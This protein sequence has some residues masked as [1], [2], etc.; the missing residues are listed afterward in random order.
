MKKLLE[1]YGFLASIGLIIIQA[2][3]SYFIVI[4][5]QETF[6]N[7]ENYPVYYGVILF[8]LNLLFIF[9]PFN[10]FGKNG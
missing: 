4:W 7:K 3:V 2:I 9:N 6:P 1:K 10:I 8:L 5:L